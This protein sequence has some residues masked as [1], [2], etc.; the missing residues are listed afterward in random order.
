MNKG[1]TYNKRM[2]VL[3]NASSILYEGGGSILEDYLNELFL[4]VYPVGTIYTSTS[5]INPTEYFGGTWEIYGSGKCLVGVDTSQTEFNTSMK[6][7]GSKSVTLNLNQ[8]PSHA[9][10][11][12]HTGRLLYW[13]SGLTG[14]GYPNYNGATPIQTTWDARTANS[15]GGQAHTNLQPY[16]TVYFWRRTA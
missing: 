16:I 1:N 5:D 13:D 11:M 3:I 7:G 4:K 10:N 14:M 8:I 6:S 2:P 12:Y 15:G 9:H